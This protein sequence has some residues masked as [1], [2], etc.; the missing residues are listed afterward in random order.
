MIEF[1]ETGRSVDKAPEVE[2]TR[3]P[4]WKKWPIALAGS[5][6]GFIALGVII[7][8]IRDKSGRETKISVPDD[9]KVVVEGPRKNVEIKP[10]ANGP[11]E[12]GGTSGPTSD[13]KEAGSEL[14][15][16]GAAGNEVRQRRFV[17]LFNGKDL[18]GWENL[19]PENGSSWKVENGILEGSGGGGGN[20]AVLVSKRQNF[21]NFRLHAR[22]D[23]LSTAVSAGSRC[24]VPLRMRAATGTSS[25]MGFG[26]R[27]SRGSRP[28]EVLQRNQ[29]FTTELPYTGRYGPNRCELR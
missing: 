11:E 1:R 8:T 2:P 26:Q 19:R 24:G 4:P 25:V 22:F 20:N 7:I 16:K 15:G 12:A 17:S 27:Q 5:L 14:N 3:R 28:S 23:T 6:F 13:S 9:S 29:N 18:T 10:S 21:K